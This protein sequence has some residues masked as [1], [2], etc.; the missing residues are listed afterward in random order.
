VVYRTKKVASL[1]A[2][3]PDSDWLI[4]PFLW[5]DLFEELDSRGNFVF[6]RLGT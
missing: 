5:I 4:S 3:K 2:A 1:I 6:A